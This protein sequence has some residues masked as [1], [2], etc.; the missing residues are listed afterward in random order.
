MNI[1]ITKLGNGYAICLP[2]EIMDQAKLLP[3]DSLDITAS[4]GE[5]VLKAA[6]RTEAKTF[7]ALYNGFSDVPQEK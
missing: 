6:K 7:D 4:D 3:T 5:I 2:K 1:N